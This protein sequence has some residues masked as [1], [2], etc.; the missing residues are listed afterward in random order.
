MVVF[1]T[2]E[3]RSE[4]LWIQRQ[5]ASLT[6]VGRIREAL[7]EDRF[8]LYS[9]PIVP[10]AG[11]R[12][13]EEVLIRMMGRKGELILPGAFLGAAEQYGLIGEID[14][15]VLRQAVGLAAQGRHVG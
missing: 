8:V 4:R 15:W 9:Q 14:Q 2:S 6:W 7:D 13:S 5:L 11:G 1:A 12:P 3:E 10:L